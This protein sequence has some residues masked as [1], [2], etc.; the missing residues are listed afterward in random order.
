MGGA[1]LCIRLIFKEID[2]D[3]SKIAEVRKR[4]AFPVT[5]HARF[6]GRVD[7]KRPID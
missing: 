3:F 2:S 5:Q 1:N 4:Y 6:L 7:N